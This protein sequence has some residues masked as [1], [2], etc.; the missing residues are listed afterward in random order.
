MPHQILIHVLANSP[1][2][3]SQKRRQDKRKRCT[4]SNL[5]QQVRLINL[6]FVVRE[7][8]VMLCL[9]IKGKSNGN[10]LIKK[11]ELITKEKLNPPNLEDI[12]IEVIYQ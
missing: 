2:N 10:H 6:C 9:E 12:T 5:N 3:I 11:L 4:M 1:K 7:Q 8:V